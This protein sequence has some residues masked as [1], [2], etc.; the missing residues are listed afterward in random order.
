M[1]QKLKIAVFVDFDNIE[2]GVKSMLHREFDVAA[3]LDAL[4]ERGEIAATFAYIVNQYAIKKGIHILKSFEN[5]SG[6]RETNLRFLL[7]ISGEMQR[8]GIKHLVVADVD[9]LSRG[10]AE[11]EAIREFFK[12]K[13]WSLHFVFAPRTSVRNRAHVRLALKIFSALL[14]STHGKRA[15]GGGRKGYGSTI[16]E[17]ATL[18]RILA[19]A[20]RGLTYSAIASQLEREGVPTS[21]GKTWHP[22]TVRRIIHRQPG[23]KAPRRF[24]V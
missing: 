14:N 5:P 20:Y 4:K 19:M 16:A 10:L 9:Q 15:A 6:D 8:R 18:S 12:F 21:S 17:R 1:E 13:S 2:V 24:T 7:D 3:V 11:Q 23:G 22:N